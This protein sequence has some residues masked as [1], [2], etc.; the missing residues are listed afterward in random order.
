MLGGS[1]WIRA[2]YIERPDFAFCIEQHVRPHVSKP[3][4]EYPNGGAALVQLRLTL[5][6][7]TP[8]LTGSK[9]STCM[10]KLT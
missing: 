4:Q 5:R 7:H 3:Y 1:C 9:I 10:I 8:H 6:G 2:A